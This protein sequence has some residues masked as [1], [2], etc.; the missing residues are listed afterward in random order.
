MVIVHGRVTGFITLHRFSA[1]G[2]AN[3]PPGPEGI[4]SALI[5][6]CSEAETL[7]A[8]GHRGV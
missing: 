8:P 2:Q 6:C 3:D 1:A 5:H 4:A 7:K